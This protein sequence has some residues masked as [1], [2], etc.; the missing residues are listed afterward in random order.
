MRNIRSG[1][2][3]ALLTLLALSLSLAFTASAQKTE[4]QQEGDLDP[5]ILTLPILQDGE[6]VEATFD[7][8][9]DAQLYAFNATEGD[10]ITI[11]MTQTD[12]SSVL[13]PYIVV[14]TAMGDV[15]A[16]DDDS[17]EEVG[18]SSL[19]TDLELPETGSYFILATTYQAINEGSLE[20]GEGEEQE[21]L[22]YEIEVSGI[23]QP[24]EITEGF[25]Y[26]A[27]ELEVGQP[28]VQIELTADAPIFFVTFMAEEGDSVT[29]SA[30]GA[31]ENSDGVSDI[32]TLLYVFDFQGNRIAVD[33]D[34]GSDLTYSSQIGGLEIPASGLYLVFVT[35]YNFDELPDEGIEPTEGMI[36]FSIE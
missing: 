1:A 21:G 14:M 32:D 4:T 29:V 2:R 30:S 24:E 7:T 6:A 23:T 10:V 36:T 19:I 15:I 17:G 35:S 8:N 27:G 12:E 5:S 33:D 20:Q 18:L 13:D 31:D 22:N 25:Q 9:L 11:S 28:E 16:R 3:L 26:F 34:S